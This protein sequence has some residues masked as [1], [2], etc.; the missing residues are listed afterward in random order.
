LPRI[1]RATLRGFAPL[2]CP[3]L[4]SG[5]PSGRGVCLKFRLD[6]RKNRSHMLFGQP[7]TAKP[8]NLLDLGCGQMSKLQ[9]AVVAQ[10]RFDPPSDG[11]YRRG[12]SGT[13]AP[14]ASDKGSSV[15]NSLWPRPIDREVFRA[16][17]LASRACHEGPSPLRCCHSVRESPRRAY[18][19]RFFPT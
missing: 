3:G 10:Q 12:T 14:R 4:H 17:R 2:L 11:R 6:F 9:W 1:P 15:S 19:L 16:S 5:G 18:P 8:A 7:G 13:T